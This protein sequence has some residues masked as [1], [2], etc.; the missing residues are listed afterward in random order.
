MGRQ[1]CNNLIIECTKWVLQAM[2]AKHVILTSDHSALVLKTMTR[3]YNTCN[4]LAICV[5]HVT[6]ELPPRVQVMDNR[7][8]IR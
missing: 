1:G 4:T 8:A 2:N 5:Y 7:Q 6:T 3:D